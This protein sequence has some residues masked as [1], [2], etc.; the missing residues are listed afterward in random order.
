MSALRHD[1]VE[2]DARS[3]I[4]PETDDV[5]LLGYLSES[6]HVV[7]SND[8]ELGRTISELRQEPFMVGVYVDKLYRAGSEYPYVLTT[9]VERGD[10]LTLTG[11]KRWS[12]PP[13]RPSA[14]PSRPASPP[15]WCGWGSERSSAAASACCR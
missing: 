2:F 4:G 10:T 11:P 15:T 8:K 14:Y 7:A 9:K 13:P 1:L 5:T 3:H 12:I 6:M